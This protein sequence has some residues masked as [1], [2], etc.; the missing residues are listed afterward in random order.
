MR[1]VGILAAAFLT[2]TAVASGAE[3]PKVELFIDVST[4]MKPFANQ[5]KEAIAKVED[6]FEKKGFEVKLLGFGEDVKELKGVKSYRPEE[7]DTNYS[8]FL[9][10]LETHEDTIAVVIT[11]GKIPS[12][13][14]GDIKKIKEE[15]ALLNDSGNVICTLTAGEPSKLVRDFSTVVGSYKNYKKVLDECLSIW[16]TLHEDKKGNKTKT[17]AVKPSVPPPNLV[18]TVNEKGFKDL[19]TKEQKAAVK[20]SGAQV[21]VIIKTK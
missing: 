4:S 9:R 1:K 14:L 21:E 15:G 16:D 5:T 3:K 20:I 2:C 19:G 7:H 12:K 11:D 13:R 17:L 8:K 10:H 18:K 6:Y